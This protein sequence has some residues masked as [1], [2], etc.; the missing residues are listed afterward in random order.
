MSDF[1]SALY[2]GV[3]AHRRLRPKK[4]ALRYRTYALLVDLDEL[5]AL[6][7]ALRLF[8]RNR[9]N[10]FS[11]HDRDYGVGDATPLREQVER[12]MRAAGLTPD[13]GAIRLLTMPRILGFAFNPLSLYFCH[14]SNGAIRAIL[15]EVNNTFG[16]RHSY[17]LPVDGER[18]APIRQSCA[19]QFY[20]SP[21]MAM[22]MAYDF[23]VAPPAETVSIT[24]VERDGAGVTLTATQ[25][26]SRVPLTDRALARVFI[27]HP[28]LTLKVV[29]AI[30]FEALLL[31][32]K[33][34]RLQARPPAPEQAVTIQPAGEGVRLHR[35]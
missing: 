34:M 9:F 26:Q 33:G 5:P 4:H 21:F 29:A 8:S 16:Q 1:A 7:G 35:E 11:F 18:G 3:V 31:W 25:D 19:K 15:Y 17:F 32:A 24:V 14:A 22:D 12:H 20:V 30:H 23:T 2:V 6:D 10:L 13:G 28:L 27:T